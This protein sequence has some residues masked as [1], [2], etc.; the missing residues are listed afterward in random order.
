MIHFTCTVLYIFLIGL[1]AD[2][3]YLDIHINL[4]TCSLLLYPRSSCNLFCYGHCGLIDDLSEFLGKTI[5]GC[6]SLPS[7]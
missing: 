5:S 3:V 2:R 6:F 7:H 4:C 1:F